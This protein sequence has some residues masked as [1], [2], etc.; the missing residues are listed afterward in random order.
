M[1][2]QASAR[3]GPVRRMGNGGTRI[4]ADHHR[5][6]DRQSHGRARRRGPGCGGH[7]RQRGAG[8]Q[9]RACRH[10]RR[11]TV[12]HSERHPGHVHRPGHDERLPNA[13]ATRRQGQRRRPRRGRSAGP[14]GWRHHGKRHRDRRVPNAPGGDRRAIVGVDS[15][16]A[17]GPADLAA[18]L[19]RLHQ[20]P[21]RRRCPPAEPGRAADG[22][23]RSGQR[24]D[25]RHFRHRH[26]QQRHHGRP[27]PPAARSPRS[28]SSPRG[29]RPS[30]AA[31]AACRFRR[32]RAAARTASADRFYDYERNSDWNANTWQARQNGHAGP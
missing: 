28:R 1:L 24:H 11:R 3:A 32:S 22:R 19:P 25:R 2:E 10:Q 15:H 8:H 16:A 5:R 26:R 27:E 29:I 20:D 6:R 31:R 9:D 7:H 13:V 4:G 12:R 14:A 21:D 18:H 17:R 30:T 23:R